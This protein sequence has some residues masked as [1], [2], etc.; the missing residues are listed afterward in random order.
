[1]ILKSMSATLMILFT[2]LSSCFQPTVK[3]Y[4][5]IYTS[6]LPRIG[7][8]IKIQEN[9]HNG[10]I[11]PMSAYMIY[12]RSDGSFVMGGCDLQVREAGKYSFDRDSISFYDIY[13]FRHKRMLSDKR[14]FYD[15]KTNSIYYR[16]PNPD[17]ET[18]TQYP[19]SIAILE[20]DFI[21][22]HMGFLRNQ[23]MSLDSL[24]TLNKFLPYNEQMDWVERE[25]RQKRSSK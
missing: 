22:S 18:S 21:R 24:L 8:L 1:M 20:L 16:H 6:H 13:S 5:G 2:I 4:V 23:E 17:L 11:V 19:E 9:K 12:L 3:S 25:L 15:K 10:K 7:P 14:F